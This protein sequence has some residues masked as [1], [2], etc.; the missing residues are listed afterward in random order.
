MKF[1]N[2]P[3]TQIQ[4][5]QNIFQEQKIATPNDVII[6]CLQPIQDKRHYS[7]WYGGDVI[8]IDRNQRRMLLSAQGDNIA[9]LIERS[10]KN[11]LVYVKDKSNMG[12]LGFA[13]KRY[14]STN[15]ELLQA[16]THTH[17]K[18]VLNFENQNWW[19]FVLTVPDSNAIDGY[20]FTHISDAM[21]EDDL[22]LCV[23]N[24]LKD[25]Y[26]WWNMNLT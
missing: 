16:I 8:A 15:E 20:T 9:F 14:L 13:L 23:A 6:T 10:T 5:L 3:E 12:E 25:D 22:F 17:P 18:Y 1:V 7:Y 2:F 21:D 19:E 24:L 4:E 11:H 26:P